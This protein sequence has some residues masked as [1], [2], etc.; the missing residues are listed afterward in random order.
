M[1]SNEHFSVSILFDLPD[2]SD[3]F[4]HL[5]QEILF[6]LGFHVRS[7]SLLFCYFAI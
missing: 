2:T 4:D 1:K 6:S 7:L 3:I 5:L